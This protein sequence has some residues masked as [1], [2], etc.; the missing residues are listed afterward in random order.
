MLTMGV[1]ILVINGGMLLLASRLAG[2]FGVNFYVDGFGPALW[3]ALVVSV[4]SFF[5][6]MFVRDDREDEEQ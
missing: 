5:L 4:A 6:N 2:V 3:G 1:F